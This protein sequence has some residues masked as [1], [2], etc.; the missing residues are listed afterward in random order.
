MVTRKKTLF[1]SSESVNMKQADIPAEGIEIETGSIRINCA[2]IKN[3]ILFM[4]GA[5]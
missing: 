5:S 2:F 4:L 1:C 3:R